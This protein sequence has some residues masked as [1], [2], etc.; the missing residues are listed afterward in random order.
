MGTVDPYKRE[1][2]IKLVLDN[3]EQAQ[4]VN[5]FDNRDEIRALLA[6]KLKKVVEKIAGND[7][8]A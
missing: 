5:V 3:I 2:L 1:E 8:D 7:E 6:K 4:C